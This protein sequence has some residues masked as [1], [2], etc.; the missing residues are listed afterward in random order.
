MIT[1]KKG[2]YED[3]DSLVGLTKFQDDP[4]SK[5][6]SL[7]LNDPEEEDDSGEDE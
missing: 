5:A 6:F 7:K 1:H 2:L 3:G 4:F